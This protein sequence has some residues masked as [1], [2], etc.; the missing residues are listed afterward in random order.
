MSYYYLAGPYSCDP[1]KMYER[2]LD[3][4]DRL[5]SA[6]HVVYSPIAETHHWHKRFPH[7]YGRWIHRD[8]QILARCDGLIRL[9]GESPGT[10]QEQSFAES[11]GLPIWLGQSPVDDF[12]EGRPPS[13]PGRPTTNH[14]KSPC[15]EGH[16]LT[17]GDRN[18]SYG[19]PLYDYARTVLA[20]FATCG[21]KIS[22]LVWPKLMIN[23]KLS[24]ECHA[25]KHDNLVDICGYTETYQM[26]LDEV[27][28]IGLTEFLKPDSDPI[29]FAVA[30][31][32][33]Q[34]NAV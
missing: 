6:G 13:I 9:P 23:V 22:P 1:D 18:E 29:E 16:R 24:R 33:K 7:D 27:E 30:I 8:L 11:R 10:D 5:F 2:H 19:H 32:S 12:I 25:P 20:D 17:N 14:N 31:L 28:R 4:A 15:L 3:A 34:K 21:V 26:C